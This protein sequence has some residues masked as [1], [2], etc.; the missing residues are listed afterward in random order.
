MGTEA[1]VPG[2]SGF[3]VKATFNLASEVYS[4]NTSNGSLSEQLISAKEQSMAV[5]K[6]FITKHNISIDV[7]DELVEGSEE[8]DD[9]IIISEKPSKKQK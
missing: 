2:T 6:D 9:D 1:N 4:V 8:E 5:L 3:H 7:P